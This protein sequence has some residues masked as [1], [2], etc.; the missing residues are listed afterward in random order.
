MDLPAQRTEQVPPLT[1]LR[2]RADKAGIE[3]RLQKLKEVK[4][5][6]G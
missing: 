3:A 2:W 1:S 4:T 6:R 5:E